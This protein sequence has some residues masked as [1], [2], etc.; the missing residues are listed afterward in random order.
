MLGGVACFACVE[1]FTLATMFSNIYDND[2]VP[3]TSPEKN[4]IPSFWGSEVVDD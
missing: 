4:S 2:K 3:G 1:K